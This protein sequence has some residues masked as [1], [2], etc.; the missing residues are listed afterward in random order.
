VGFFRWVYPKNP[1]GFL[2]YVPGCL[3]PGLLR[4]RGTFTLILVFICHF[5]FELGDIRDRQTERQARRV[6]QP[7]R[8]SVWQSLTTHWIYRKRQTS[9]YNWKQQ[10]LRL[11]WPIISGHLTVQQHQS[12][13]VIRQKAEWRFVCIR[14]VAAAI[15]NRMFRLYV[16]PLNLT[17]P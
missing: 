16:R 2:G 3:N 10:F 9:S 17:S 12:T 8:M 4:P 6:L 14:Q 5:V 1:P 7:I 15:C 11:L 13:K